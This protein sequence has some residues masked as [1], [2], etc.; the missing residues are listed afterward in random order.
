MRFVGEQRDRFGVEPVLRVLKIPPSTYYGWP[1]S[2]TPPSGTV[3]T[4]R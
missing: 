4:R 2:A 1:S 3:T